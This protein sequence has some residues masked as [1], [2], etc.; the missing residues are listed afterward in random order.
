[1]ASTDLSGI[2]VASTTGAQVPLASFARYTRQVVPLTVNHQGVFPAVTLSFNL[3]PGVAFSQAV[4]AISVL[5]R[6]LHTPATLQGAFQGTAQAYQAS[7]TST[8]LLI[9][10]AILVI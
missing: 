7:L 6:Q 5:G 8:P 9:L 10:A 3:A 4:D 2:Y 1:M